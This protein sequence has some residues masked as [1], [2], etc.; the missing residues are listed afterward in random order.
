MYS[1]CHAYKSSSC[2]NLVVLRTRRRIGNRA[3]SVAAPRAW[4]KLPMELKLLRFT[5]IRKHFCF[6]LS[7]GTRIRIDSVMRPRSSS[8]GR[9]TGNTRLPKNYCGRV[10]LASREICDVIRHRHELCLETVV[11]ICCVLCAQRETIAVVG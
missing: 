10:H 6:I 1:F 2:G 8:R 4:N 11:F 3:F 5:V 7:T 9:N